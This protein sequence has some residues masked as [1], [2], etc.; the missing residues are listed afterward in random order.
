MADEPKMSINEK[1]LVDALV[2]LRRVGS[3]S[4]DDSEAKVALV[5]ESIDTELDRIRAY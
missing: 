4:R 3:P 5:L 2:A 1:A